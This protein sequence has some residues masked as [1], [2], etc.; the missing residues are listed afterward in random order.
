MGQKKSAVNRDPRNKP[1]YLGQ[2]IFYQGGKTIQWRKD[3]LF[4]KQCWESCTAA[5]KS[6]KLEHTLTP[7]TKINSKRLKDLNMR[8][9]T[10]KLLEENIGKKLSDINHSNIF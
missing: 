5:Y 2:L 4:G 7:Y 3:S 10:I 9:D 8:H 6:V 1:T